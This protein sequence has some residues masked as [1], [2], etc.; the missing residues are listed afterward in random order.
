[1]TGYTVFIVMFIVI[2]YIIST[3]KFGTFISIITIY[4]YG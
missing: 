2:V 4:D 3:H 1:L